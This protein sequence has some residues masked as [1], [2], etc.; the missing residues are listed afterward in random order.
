M[1]A[2]FVFIVAKL[3]RVELLKSAHFLVREKSVST[4]TR[5]LNCDFASSF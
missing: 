1:L 4:P 5:K 3:E 2:V